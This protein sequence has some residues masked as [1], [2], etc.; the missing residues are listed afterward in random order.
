MLSVDMH[1]HLIPGIDDG[2]K[3]LDESLTMLR[4]MANLGYSKVITTPH[5]MSDYY[6]NNQKNIKEGLEQLAKGIKASDIKI[7]IEAAAEYFVDDYFLNLLETEEQLLTFSGKHILIEFS[8]IGESIDILDVIF[9]LTSRGYI[10]ILA[11]PERYPYYA[12]R[13]HL[14]ESIYQQ[15][16]RLQVNLLSL[17]GHYGK[18]QQELGWKLIK[19]DIV[20]YLGTDAHRIEHLNKISKLSTTRKFQNLVQTKSFLNIQL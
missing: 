1:S 3:S 13:L 2:S 11:H 8:M 4:S 14:F 18:Q 17:C 7:E 12:N 16:C 20:D 5:I 9:K 6:P 15:G 10:P 19:M